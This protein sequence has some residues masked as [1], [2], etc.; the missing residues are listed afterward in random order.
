MAQALTLPLG[1]APT[2]FS[3]AQRARRNAN[4]SRLLCPQHLWVPISGGQPVA[5]SPARGYKGQEQGAG[6]KSGRGSSRGT[7]PS[8]ARSCGRLRTAPVPAVLHVP[9][10]LLRVLDVLGAGPAGAARCLEAEGRAGSGGRLWGCCQ[11]GRGGGTALGW[12]GAKAPRLLQSQQAAGHK[13][14]AGARGGAELPSTN[15]IP[16]AGTRG[17]RGACPQP[18]PVRLPIGG[19]G[20][21]RLGTG[22]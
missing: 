19:G 20:G 7:A 21:S 11:P 1:Q 6:P 10:V 2:T 16:A 17:H 9:D 8:A 4:P 12:R 15:P 14:T 22:R 3:T 18:G 13:D 5:W